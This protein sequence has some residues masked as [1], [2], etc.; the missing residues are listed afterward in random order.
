[1]YILGGYFRQSKEKKYIYIYIYI[2][3]GYFRQ[4]KEKYIYKKIES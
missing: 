2:L 3:G 4:S 1:M